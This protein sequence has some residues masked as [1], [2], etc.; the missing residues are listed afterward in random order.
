MSRQSLHDIAVEF[1]A[2]SQKAIKYSDGT[3]EFW[4]PKSI[5][6]ADGIVQVEEEKNGSITLTAPEWWL[7]ERGLV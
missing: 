6:H 2:E 7:A 1:M 4:V 3:K 5:M